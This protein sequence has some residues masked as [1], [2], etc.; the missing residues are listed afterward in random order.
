MSKKL[1]QEE[2]MSVAKEVTEFTA[3]GEARSDGDPAK[4]LES[5][6]LFD[7]FEFWFNIVTP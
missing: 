1:Q 3:A 6:S 7:T 4:L 5:L 2:F